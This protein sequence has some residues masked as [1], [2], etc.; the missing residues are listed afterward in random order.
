MKFTKDPSPQMRQNLLQNE[1]PCIKIKE[2]KL[3]AIPA[4]MIRGV[5][6]LYIFIKYVMYIHCIVT[7]L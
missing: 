1:L 5:F 4:T 7:I 6:N 3:D 2:C